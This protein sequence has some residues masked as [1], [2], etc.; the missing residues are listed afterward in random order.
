M[1]LRSTAGWARDEF[2]AATGFDYLDLRGSEIGRLAEEG[3]LLASR[4]RIRL[5]ASAYFTSDAVFAALV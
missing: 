1:G 2:R 4:D 3:L 5:A